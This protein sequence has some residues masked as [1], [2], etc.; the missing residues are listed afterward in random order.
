MNAS[1]GQPRK[2]SA[3]APRSLTAWLPREDPASRRGAAAPWSLRRQS[4]GQRSSMVPR[5]IVGF[6]LF[7]SLV[8]LSRP[9]A[10]AAALPLI[11]DEQRAKSGLK[12]SHLR[13][14]RGHVQWPRPRGLATRS[15]RESARISLWRVKNFRFDRLRGFVAPL[16]NRLRKCDK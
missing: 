8:P 11:L 12:T 7:R 9:R 10:V 6:H 15:S 5:E 4:H 3:F 2:N 13:H 1:A 16:S 14:H